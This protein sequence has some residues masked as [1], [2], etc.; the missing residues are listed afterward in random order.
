MTRRRNAG[1]SRC[2]GE[3]VALLCA[4][5]AVLAAAAGPGPAG[6]A[7]PALATIRIDGGPAAGAARVGTAFRISDRELVTAAHAVAGCGAPKIDGHGQSVSVR[8]GVAGADVA[9][10]TMEPAPGQV[11]A[12][13]ERQPPVGT[14]ATHVGYDAGGLVVLESRAIGLAWMIAEGRTASVVQVYGVGAGSRAH[15]GMS[16]SPVIVAGRVVGVHVAEQARRGRV[17]A[18]PIATARALL[19]SAGGAGPADERLPA[20]AGAP[21]AA[22]ASAVRRIRCS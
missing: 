8:L 4:A 13:D 10:I 11:M 19:K 9:V 7:D 3:R 18:V 1:G 20:I 22:S 17:L 15:Y 5:L 14:P 12:I 16:G 21:E 6:A 2:A